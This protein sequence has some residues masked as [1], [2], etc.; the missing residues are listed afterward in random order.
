MGRN[1]CSDPSKPKQLSASTAVA[2]C[3]ET[4][5]RVSAAQAPARPS[6]G[7]DT[8]ASDGSKGEG[9][10]GGALRSSSWLPTRGP[11]AHV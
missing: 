6:P 11:A 10:P 5:L 7:W 2:T 1:R 4:H 8:P 3:Q 9:D